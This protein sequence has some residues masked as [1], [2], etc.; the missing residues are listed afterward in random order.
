MFFFRKTKLFTFE[1]M[2]DDYEFTDLDKFFQGR[3]KEYKNLVKCF[4][5]YKDTQGD[6]DI[7]EVKNME[8]PTTADFENACLEDN[9]YKVKAMWAHPNKSITLN[10]MLL[11][12]IADKLAFDLFYE[13]PYKQILQ[14]LLSDPSIVQHFDAFLCDPSDCDIDEGFHIKSLMF[15]V[16][17]NGQSASFL[18]QLSQDRIKIK[19]S[20]F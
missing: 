2:E 11:Y 1:V 17:E 14:F 13:S 7:E 12:R 10:P 15:H 16:E 8:G 3:G 20:F 4:N 19:N 9:L 6:K 5:R 18:H